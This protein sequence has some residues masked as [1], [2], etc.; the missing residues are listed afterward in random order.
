[1]LIEH[2]QKNVIIPQKQVGSFVNVEVDVL[3]KMVEKSLSVFTS[4]YENR[5]TKIEKALGI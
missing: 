5:L 2:T 1:M 4:A 3:A